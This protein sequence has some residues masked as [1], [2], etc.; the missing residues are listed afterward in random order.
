MMW[1]FP[2]YA[3]GQ[4]DGGED[5]T[6]FVGKN[7]TIHMLLHKYTNG[8]APGWPGLHAFSRDG[9]DWQV[10]ETVDGKGAY[11][12]VVEWAA[13]GATKFARRE[14]P[15]LTV[16][17]ATGTPLYLNTGCQLQANTTADGKGCKTCQYS[18]VVLQKVRSKSRLIVKSQL[19]A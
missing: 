18:F 6:L 2:N 17:P 5:P 12:F 16:D 9:V 10:S 4:C 7:G 15:E 19:V 3:N 14:R 11:S 13:G 8:A 1:P